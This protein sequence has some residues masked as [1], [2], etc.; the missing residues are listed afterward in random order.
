[1]NGFQ[2][3]V[4]SAID[5][6]VKKCKHNFCIIRALSRA[7]QGDVETAIA[8]MTFKNG[9]LGQL[10]IGRA[11]VP[12]YDIETEIIGTEGSLRV[13]PVPFKNRT[14][15]MNKDGAVQECVR[16]FPE[17][18]EDAYILELMEFVSCVQNGTKPGVNV[19]D[20]TNATIVAFAGTEA[21]K[22]GKIVK[23]D[24]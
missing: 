8:Q 16:N 2:K 20:G 14:V 24:Y 12:G 6:K 5:C 19:Y 10:H 15:I 22:T 4:N 21:L 18:F 7:Q 11:S 13:S 17:R 1:M 9:G 23:I 3:D